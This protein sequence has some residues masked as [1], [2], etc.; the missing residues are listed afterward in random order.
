MTGRLFR[1]AIRIKDLGEK[2]KCRP[3][4]MAGLK[5]KDKAVSKSLSWED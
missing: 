3:L 4:V 5:L 2:L 1:I